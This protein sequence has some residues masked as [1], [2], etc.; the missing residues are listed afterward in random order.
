MTVSTSSNSVVYRGNGSATNFAVPF[1]VLSEDHLV[2]TRRVYATGEEDH[3]Y[4]GTDYSYSG[5]GA[6]SG[7]L[8]LSG[9]ALSS[10]Y[11]L[12]IERVVDYTQDL[13]IVNAGGF[14]PESVEG[15][16]DL[17]VMGIQ[18][19]AAEVGR[20]VRVGPGT[21]LPLLA[22]S[23]GRANT[24]VGFDNT[25]A[26]SLLEQS[27]LVGSPGGN[28][29]SIGLFSNLSIMTIPA[30]TNRVRTSDGHDYVY[31]AAVDAD[32]VENNPLTAVL[33]AGDRGWRL[34]TDQ[35]VTPY[36]LGCGPDVEDN[37]AGL[38]AFIDFLEA[39]GAPGCCNGVF[40][41]QTPMIWGDED[42]IGPLALYEDLNRPVSMFGTLTLLV[43]A[44]IAGNV[45]NLYLSGN[46]ANVHLNIDVPELV[47]EWIDRPFR[48]GVYHTGPAVFCRW[49]SINVRCAQGF[50]VFYDGTGLNNT[51]GGELGTSYF[52]GCGS[53]AVDSEEVDPS[54][55]DDWF[56][57]ANYSA[58]AAV[59]PGAYTQETTFTVSALP[60][61]WVDGDKM[62]VFV[63]IGNT[64]EQLSVKTLNRV[65]SKIVLYGAPRADLPA[66][67]TLRYVF[68]GAWG[69]TGGNSGVQTAHHIAAS[70]CG[71]GVQ[72]SA[73]YS[74][75]IKAT[76]QSCVIGYL[77]G[78]NPF[79][80]LVGGEAV[81]YCEDNHADVWAV[82]SSNYEHK[83]SSNFSL[84]L[85]KVFVF[86]PR[87]ADG[88]LIYFAAMPGLEINYGG[89]THRYLNGPST[90]GTIASVL[91]R[92]DRPHQI[93]PLK[94]DAAT[95]LVDNTWVREDGT[96]QA[97]FNR[98]FG[99][100]TAEV[101]VAGTGGGGA[102]TSVTMSFPAGVTTRKFN[103]GTLGANLVL[104]SW[105]RIARVQVGIDLSDNTNFLVNVVSGT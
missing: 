56:L 25:G 81:V 47:E 91:I 27:D 65:D 10:T 42:W 38:V 50:G 9:A 17:I 97:D 66:T 28:V 71:I 85:S 99:Y 34:A 60:P 6:S 105:T 95:I 74:G 23:A 101:S 8:T 15:Q 103:G 75:T 49:G 80:A 33:D 21:A 70:S 79:Q 90:A 13:D 5:V 73:T 40:E 41:I 22:N 45:I 54:D 24:I 12:V 58:R 16:L 104:S 36:M 93:Y 14:Y 88:S 72:N 20:A 89:T 84:S 30:G 18:Q 100:R 53:G 4:V 11:E 35:L 77:V 1:K 46:F 69:S 29:M 52:Y 2:V 44:P 31:D 68:G 55:F 83:I 67:G 43:T 7:T 102:P 26:L 64:Y 57:T 61:T 32:Y 86:Q 19:L 82:F 87:Q 62:R 3:V 78:G 51:A 48:H 76:N 94:T 96:T 59:N 63:E 37:S 92:F 98:L 39:T